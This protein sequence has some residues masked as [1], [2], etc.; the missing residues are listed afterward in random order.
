MEEET[1]TLGSTG[2]GASIAQDDPENWFTVQET[3]APQLPP[4]SLLHAA[5]N[6]AELSRSVVSDSL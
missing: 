2:G 5:L 4:S 1:K 3:P 6:C